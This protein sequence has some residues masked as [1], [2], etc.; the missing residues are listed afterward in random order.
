MSIRMLLALILA[1][2][3]AACGGGGGDTPEDT[4]PPADGTAFT[5][6]QR[7]Q[8]T[9]RIAVQYEKLLEA[10]DPA[11]WDALRA[12]TLQQPEFSAAGLGD[13]LLWARFTDGRMFVYFDNWAKANLPEPPEAES[14]PASPLA[15]SADPPA[16][17]TQRERPLAAAAAAPPEIPGSDRAT[18]LKLV[19]EDFNYA[20]GLIRRMQSALQPRGWKFDTE[21]ELTVATLKKLQGHGFVFLTSHASVYD[22]HGVPTY[23]IMTETFADAIANFANKD[24]LDDG[25]LMYSR[26]R[27]S[28]LTNFGR[29][30]GLWGGSYPRLTASAKFVRKYMSFAPH[31]LVVLVM[32][33][34]GTP[35]AA[36][37][38]Q[39]FLDKGAGTVMGWDGYANAFGYTAVELLV[40]RMTG[41]NKR[42]QIGEGVYLD[43]PAVPNRAFEK[44]DVVTFLQKKG[45]LDQPGIDGKST[46]KIRFFGEGFSLFH[47]VLTSLRATGRD[48]LIL[49]GRFGTLPQ[50]LITIDGTAVA[51]DRWAADGSEIE[52]TLPTSPSDPP[53]SKGAVVV[54]VG[55]RTS[56]PRMLTS[57]RGDMEFVYEE[58]YGAEP[59]VFRNR[60]IGHLHVRADGHGVRSE[61][62]GPVSNNT[63]L[64]SVASDS[65]AEWV[66]D[67]GCAVCHL[68]QQWSGSKQGLEFSYNIDP[69][70]PYPPDFTK[71]TNNDAI[72]MVNAV[73]RKLQLFVQI[74]KLEDFTVTT[75]DTPPSSEPSRLNRP[76]STVF[77]AP[78]SGPWS[79][80]MPGAAPLKFGSGQNVTPEKYSKIVPGSN[81]SS[82][83]TRHTIQW[84]AFTASP[85]FDDRIG[86]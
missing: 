32:C 85:E 75:F 45:V 71:I 26:D 81:E 40:D 20:N 14:V 57:W 51:V 59:D 11:P 74:G 68:Y 43:P 18:F 42:V 66:A 5:A 86:R 9:A 73:D 16:A 61:V 37:L 63:Y 48:K 31:S 41:A 76:D 15:S 53:G 27:G 83:D 10:N 2:A 54:S 29:E 49:N 50:P 79:G 19:H 62:D 24:D 22:D 58:L 12:F 35:Q 17:P 64:V 65:R 56:N 21:R 8:A 80:D 78:P 30:Y 23:G 13:S 3:L 67:G 52:V 1:V 69:S 34:S 33:N 28:L 47:P 77:W 7:A 25:T 84:G 72:A 6:E 4:P 38:R 70:S 55:G 39:A 44:A 60:L 46:A 36:D 82:V